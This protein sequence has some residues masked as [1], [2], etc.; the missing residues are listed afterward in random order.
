[1]LSAFN[2][3]CVRGE[4][5]LFS[6]SG[7]IKRVKCLTCK[8]EHV[9]KTAEKAA[10][11]VKKS[12]AKKA[13]AAGVIRASDYDSLMKGRDLTRARKYK[14]ALAAMAKVRFS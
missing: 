14:P 11:G 3:S 4:R 8:T 6:F 2:L 12:A 7:T 10:A 1:M 13:A 9:Y 5:S